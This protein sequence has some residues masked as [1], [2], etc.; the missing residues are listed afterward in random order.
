M[1]LSEKADI[2]RR[3]QMREQRGMVR[4]NSHPDFKADS[5]PD[6]TSTHGIEVFGSYGKDDE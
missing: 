2:Q 4:V 1:L 6:V 3:R 5:A